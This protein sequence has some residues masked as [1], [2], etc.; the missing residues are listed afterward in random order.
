MVRLQYLSDLVGVAPGQARKMSKKKKHKKSR[1][2][3]SSPEKA[4]ED[5]AKVSTIYSL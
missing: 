5:S 2:R 1:H 4:G 3:T